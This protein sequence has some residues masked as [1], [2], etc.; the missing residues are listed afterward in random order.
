MGKDRT[1]HRY[2][3][4]GGAHFIGIPARDLTAD[5]FDALD[6]QQRAAVTGGGIYEPVATPASEGAKEATPAKEEK[7]AK[8]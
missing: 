7:P 3:G 8:K 5:E 6:E 1:A 2:I 4:E